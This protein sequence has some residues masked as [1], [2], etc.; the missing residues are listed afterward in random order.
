[1]PR[2][3]TLTLPLPDPLL[4]PNRTISMHWAQKGRHAAKQRQD[5]NLVARSSIGYGFVS[6]TKRVCLDIVIRPRKGMKKLDDDNFWAA[7]KATR[8][9]LADA[10]I[11]ANDKQFV[12]GS[13][14][15]AKERTAELVITLTEV[16]YAS[17]ERE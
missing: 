4:N 6:F 14:T 5:A 1:M 7:M 17:T 13:L 16:E 8:D 10:G 12:I 15:W 3:L 2:T 9:G 11:V